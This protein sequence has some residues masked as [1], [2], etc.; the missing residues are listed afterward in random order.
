MRRVSCT[1]GFMTWLY[2]ISPLYPR[3]FMVSAMA[4]QTLNRVAAFLAS[5][6]GYLVPVWEMALR[7]SATAEIIKSDACSCSV[8]WC[9]VEM[10]SGS[11]LRHHT[12]SQQTAQPWVRKR[13]REVETGG[14]GEWQQCGECAGVGFVRTV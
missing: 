14:V 12:K 9:K 5:F 10:S 3:L 11:R 2:P 4:A 13:R 6:T 7:D 1:S 8:S